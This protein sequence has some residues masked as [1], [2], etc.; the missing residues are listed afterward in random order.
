MKAA[1]TTDEKRQVVVEEI[2]TPRVQPGPYG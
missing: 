2:P 1:V